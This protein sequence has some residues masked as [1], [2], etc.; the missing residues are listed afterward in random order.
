[1][2]TIPVNIKEIR[3]FI[4]QEIKNSSKCHPWF[5]DE[6][7]A[8]VEKIALKILE[9]QA[10]ANK[11]IVLLSVW[12]HDLGR[13]YGHNKDHD[14]WGAEF[15]KKY[16]TEKG[17]EAEIVMGVYNACLSHRVTEVKPES[18]EAKILATADAMSHF[19]EGFYL[20]IFFAWSKRMSNYQEMKNKLMKK[21]E[22][23]YHQKIFFDESKEA[24]RPMYEAWKIV[25]ITKN[26]A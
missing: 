6:H 21:I 4:I 18:V 10:Q 13:A 15:A 2:D 25:L 16:L 8:V 23:D 22:R 11:E 3:N 24:I 5:W 7:V 9:T 14:V 12:F 20:R 26:P 1:M 19:E 17:F